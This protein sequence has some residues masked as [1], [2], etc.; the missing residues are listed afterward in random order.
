MNQSLVLRAALLSGAKWDKRLICRCCGRSGPLG[1]DPGAEND[2]PTH[3]RALWN[4]RIQGESSTERS[5]AQDICTVRKTRSGWGMT[6]V[7][8]PSAVVSPVMPC[9][10]P[11]GL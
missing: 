6:M 9:G 10:V 7:K 4:M 11:L 5:G 1:R 2:Y 3:L 8:R